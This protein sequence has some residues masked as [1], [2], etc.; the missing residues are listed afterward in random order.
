MF[1][2]KGLRHATTLSNALDDADVNDGWVSRISMSPLVA[3]PND[4][5]MDTSYR[6]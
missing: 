2:F 3:A 4:R 1:G 5:Q 6:Q